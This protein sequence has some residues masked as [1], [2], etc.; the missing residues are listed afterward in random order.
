[1][2]STAC[3]G[4]AAERFLIDDCSTRSSAHRV[5]E[6]CSPLEHSNRES[7]S[8]VVTVFKNAAEDVFF[9]RLQPVDQIADH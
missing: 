5:F 7:R 4:R 2:H 1:M 9:P 6:T 3:L 8:P